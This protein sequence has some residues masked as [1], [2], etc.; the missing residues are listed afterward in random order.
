MV[1]L[2]SIIVPLRYLAE[3]ERIYH[4]EGADFPAPSQLEAAAALLDPHG[5]SGE[6]LWVYTREVSV[7]TEILLGNPVFRVSWDFF[8]GLST[9]QDI[10]RI[11]TD[12]E[13]KRELNI[14]YV[15]A[16]VIFQV[17]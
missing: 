10:L 17:S 3:L 16:G 9:E 13:R 5:S 6:S 14:S 2:S 7:Y 8:R 15:L 12:S 1:C 4:L 11:V